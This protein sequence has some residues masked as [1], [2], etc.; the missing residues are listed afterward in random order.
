M[1][2]AGDLP[3]YAPEGQPTLGTNAKI[4]VAEQHEPTTEEPKQVRRLEAL[5][6]VR[7]VNE[8]LVQ[9]T[10]NGSEAISVVNQLRSPRAAL[11]N[12][13][14]EVKMAATRGEKSFAVAS[15]PD[16]RGFGG[17]FGMS[18]DYN[19]AFAV[20]PYYYLVGVGYTTGT[21]GAPTREQLITA[22]Q[23]LYA[24]VHR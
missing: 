12:V 17:I 2:V 4:W 8:H 24:R 6:F 14:N 19:V 23:R 16:A 10:H 7:G 21:P 22:A 20:G 11:A 3:G 5:G 18:T 13:E 15:I 9:S 1:L